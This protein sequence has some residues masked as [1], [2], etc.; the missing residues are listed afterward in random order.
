MSTHYEWLGLPMGVSY[1]EPNTD[2]S[3]G[4]A[5]ETTPGYAPSEGVTVNGALLLSNDEVVVIDGSPQDLLDWANS[6]VDTM[7]GVLRLPGKGVEAEVLTE[8]AQELEVAIKRIVDAWNGG[9]LAGTVNEAREL[10]DY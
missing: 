3:T 5:V 10:V 6:L 1:A 4:E 9:D 8:R 7:R 2:V